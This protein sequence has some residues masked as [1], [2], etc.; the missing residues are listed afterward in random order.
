MKYI[1]MCGGE[2]TKFETPKHLSVIAGERV[3]DRTIRLLKENGIEDIYI[4][5]NNPMFDT[6]GVPRLEH[7]NTYVN[8]KGKESGYWLDA[9]YPVEDKEVCYIFGDVYFREE[10]IKTIVD[11]KSRK[12]T[13]FGTGIARNKLHQNWGE[14]FAYK[15]VDNDTFKQGIADVKKMQDEGKTVRTPV[16]WELYR[17]LNGLDVNIHEVLDSTYIAIDDGSIDVDEPATIDDLNKKYGDK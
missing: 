5:S 4:S 14:P 17:Y 9:F 16:V 1:I 12:N 3:A 2:Y 15:I 11:Y 7:T 6:C 10:A 8:D 13:L